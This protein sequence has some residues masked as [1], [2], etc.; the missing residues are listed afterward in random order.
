MCI[1]GHRQGLVVTT[2]PHLCCETGRAEASGALRATQV[3]PWKPIKPQ[4]NA[5][6]RG[7]PR[8]EVPLLGRGISAATVSRHGVRLG[9][10]RVEQFVH[11]GT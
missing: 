9:S 7:Q 3:V 5:P 6:H 8:F 1:G 4:N 10:L 11:H 2:F